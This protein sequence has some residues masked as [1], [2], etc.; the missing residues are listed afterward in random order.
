MNPGRSRHVAEIDLLT[1]SGPVVL[2][3]KFSMAEFPMGGWRGFATVDPGPGRALPSGATL[4]ATLDHHLLPGAAAALGLW[5]LNGEIPTDGTA[6]D[7]PADARAVRTW[8][9]MI[10]RVVTI[11]VA[12]KNSSLWD[13]ACQ[14]H[15]ADPLSHLRRQRIWGVFKKCSPG[16]MLGGAL[17]LATGGEGQ[18]T[19][20]P[21]LPGMPTIHISQELRASLEEVPYAI[22][23]GDTFGHWL[24]SLFGRMGIRIA[25]EGAS[26]GSIGITLRDSTT[27]AALILMRVEDGPIAADNAVIS[28]MQ[29]APVP[30]ARDSLLDNPSGG[31]SQRLGNPG[32][33]E[34]LIQAAEIGTDEARVRAKFKRERAQLD[35]TRIKIFSTQPG[36]RPDAL[37]KFT[38]RPVSGAS[39]WKVHQTLHVVSSGTYRNATELVKSG[40]PWHPPI[41]PD[42]GPIFLS[43]VVNDG[44]SGPGEAVARDR[45]GRIPVSISSTSGKASGIDLPILEPMAGGVHGFMPTHRQGDLCRVL[46]H[47]P[48]YAEVAGFTYSD[49]R[50]V[51]KQ[52]ENVSMG[53][54]MHSDS[55]EWS[56]FLFQPRA[57]AEE[58]TPC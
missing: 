23:H 7:R 57:A 34:T 56:G 5:K 31:V 30:S 36:L 10:T 15:L 53:V 58:D 43:G 27:S 32:A 45:L 52:M 44:K 6:A 42:N 25:M 20:T 2:V 38:N 18:P 28:G 16:A 8:P 39:N 35:A 46:I 54:I 9:S 24:D 48:L 37:V 14:I 11:P 29:C 33:V 13:T 21:T 26:N 12:S 50:P 3:E 1:P 41:P 40:I 51:G 22:A 17:E 47:S 55:D 49:Y 19:I 4:E